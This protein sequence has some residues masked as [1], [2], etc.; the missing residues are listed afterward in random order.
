MCIL[1][2]ACG[3]TL[4]PQG[5][6]QSWGGLEP[7]LLK[8][9]DIWK[10]TSVTDQDNTGS[11]AG[12]MASGVYCAFRKLQQRVYFPLCLLRFECNG[13]IDIAICLCTN[14]T[15]AIRL[16]DSERALGV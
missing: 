4:W 10:R 5:E 1:W 12:R 2:G 11:S 3:V 8:S 14:I 15:D 13:H 6:T 16:S 9:G 7:H